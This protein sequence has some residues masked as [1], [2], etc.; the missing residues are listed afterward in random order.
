MG[1]ANSRHGSEEKCLQGF[2]EKII[3]KVNIRGP[4][5]RWEDNT[6]MDIRE[7]GLGYGLNSSG[8]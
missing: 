7:M 5:H 3:R 1:R 6:K 8:S 2:G 4:R